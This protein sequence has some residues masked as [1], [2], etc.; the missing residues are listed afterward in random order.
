MNF[1]KETQN[2]LSSLNTSQIWFIYCTTI[3]ITY[4]NNSNKFNCFLNPSHDKGFTYR[5]IFTSL[6]SKEKD[7]SVLLIGL[8]KGNQRNHSRNVIQYT[9]HLECKQN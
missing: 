6:F 8:C 1:K 2:T 4:C 5:V 7:D 3:Y 9:K